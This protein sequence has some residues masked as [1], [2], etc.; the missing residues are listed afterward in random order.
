MGHVCV[1]LDVHLQRTS[2]LSR[3]G[4]S[5]QLVNYSTATCIYCHSTPKPLDV[6]EVDSP[7]AYRLHFIYNVALLREMAEEISNK[8]QGRYRKYYHK[9][10]Q[11]EL[12]FATGDYILVEL[13]HQWNPLR[14][15]WRLED[16]PRS[17]PA[18]QN[19]FGYHS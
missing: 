14:T 12:R 9:N 17:F 1:S 8:P 15:T 6:R 13:N 16:T 2:A 18:A 4:T 7:P 10:F 3:K 5:I 11:L 19:H